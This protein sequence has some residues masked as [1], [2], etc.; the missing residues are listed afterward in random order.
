VSRTELRYDEAAT[1]H[2]RAGELFE[3]TGH[4]R[5]V[6]WA[7]YDLALLARDK[8]DLVTARAL[9]A[10]ALR[11][12]RE[13]DYW[14]AVATSAW[15]LGHVD[16]QLG[17]IDEAASLLAESLDLYLEFDDSRGVAQCF[18]ALAAVAL[19]RSQYQKSVRLLAAAA[20][21]RSALA[22]PLPQTEAAAVRHVQDALLR[23]LDRRSFDRARHDGRTMPVNAA[24]ELAKSIGVTSRRPDPPLTDRERQVAALVAAGMTNRQ[25]A[26]SAGS[27]KRPPRRTCTTSWASSAPTAGP[28]SLRGRRPRG[29][30]RG[31]RIRHAQW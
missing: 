26:R 17:E 31:R 11:D 27:R 15:G 30:S 6:V 10:E 16:V 21:L 24:V 9:F 25:V 3:R 2:R 19:A 8:G 29:W 5:G 18:E 12:F 7:R 28:K 23:L 22:L 20:G 13:L 1:R 14:W 4:R